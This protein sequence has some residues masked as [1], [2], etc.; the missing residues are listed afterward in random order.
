MSTLPCL[1][2]TAKSLGGTIKLD[3]VV[4]GEMMAVYGHEKIEIE[5]SML[6]PRNEFENKSRN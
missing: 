6:F 1:S 5:I 4:R 3:G 2:I